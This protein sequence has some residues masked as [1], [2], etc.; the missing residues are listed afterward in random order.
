MAKTKPLKL[1]PSTE[2]RKPPGSGAG[3]VDR[4]TR[5]QDVPGDG[6]HPTIVMQMVVLLKGY[7]CLVGF[8]TKNAVPSNVI[9]A[10]LK[11]SL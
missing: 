4:F 1:P 10:Y 6:A 3:W 2:I 8:L 9:A 7:H 11:Q 5:P